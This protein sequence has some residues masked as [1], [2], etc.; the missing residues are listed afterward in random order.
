MRTFS[1]IENLNWKHE[2]Y[3]ETAT[4]RPLEYRDSEHRRHHESLVSAS[5][6]CETIL[7]TL[8]NPPGV[9]VYAPLCLLQSWRR[10][11]PRYNERRPGESVPY[12]LTANRGESGREQASAHVIFENESFPDLTILQELWERE[13]GGSFVIT[14][15]GGRASLYQSKNATEPGAIEE[16][17]RFKKRL[18]K[19]SSKKKVKAK[20]PTE[21]TVRRVVEEAVWLAQND[22]PRDRLHTSGTRVVKPVSGATGDRD[23]QPAPLAVGRQTLVGL[24]LLDFVAVEIGRGRYRSTVFCHSFAD[25]QGRQYRWYATNPTPAHPR[26]YRHPGR[27]AVL[28][29]VPLTFAAAVRE[30][31]R[32]GT[33]SISRPYIRL[34]RQCAATRREYAK[35]HGIELIELDLESE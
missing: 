24:R 16:D 31:W 21:R 26:G 33:V 20:P 17:Y 1:T 12:N 19:E 18:P 29:D 5:D 35:Q 8:T 34:D 27:Y 7:G 2:S 15:A 30:I 13:T 22:R 9:P 28:P 3:E 4:K 10:V 14:S 32:D 11:L 23:I 6:W 25:D